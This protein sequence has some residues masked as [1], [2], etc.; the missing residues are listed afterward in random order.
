[1]YNGKEIPMPAWEAIRDHTKMGAL[2]VEA[3]S[4]FDQIGVF[5]DVNGEDYFLVK[6]DLVST[7]ALDP[8]SGSVV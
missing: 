6:R 1:M 8:S 4:Y 7:L 3:A 5:A 2:A